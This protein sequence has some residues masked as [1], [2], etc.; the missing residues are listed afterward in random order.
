MSSNDLPNPGHPEGAGG[1][2][3]GTFTQLGDEL[4]SD[5]YASRVASSLARSNNKRVNLHDRDAVEA[6]NIARAERNLN[7]ANKRMDDNHIEDVSDDE[8]FLDESNPP[9][10]APSAKPSVPSF[11]TDTVDYIGS[12]TPTTKSIL[13]TLSAKGN[14]L[15]GGNQAVTSSTGTTSD[16]PVFT[17]ANTRIVDGEVTAFEIPRVLLNLA[18]AKVH[19]PLTLLTL[20]SLRKIHEDPAC[21]KM[22]KGLVTNDPKLFVMDTSSGFPPE[23][24]LQP[25]L[26]YEAATNFI[27]LLKQVADDTT[28]QRFTDHRDFCLS[29]DEFG[30]NFESVLAFD[31]E[32][33]RRFFNTHTFPSRVAYL[34]RWRNVL[35][36]TTLSQ[37]SSSSSRYQPYPARKPEGSSSVNMSNDGKPFRRSK[38]DQSSEHLLCVI[39]GRLGHRASSCTHTHTTKNVPVVSM[40]TDKLILK[41]SSAPICI[42]FNIGR[43]TAPRHPNEVVHVCSICGSK[44]HGANSKSCN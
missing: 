23:S 7:R 29:R 2:D 35:I 30:D 24:S 10:N 39:C 27:R 11:I 14:V 19:I 5:E 34:D 38:G 21:V 28:V 17:E 25:H 36:K 3:T 16:A 15:P 20:A 22:K 37:Q 33:R 32:I 18:R 31:V 41:S 4:L 8:P 12:L 43:C 6:E 40:W 13:A 42:S 26:F 9:E 44:N 1:K